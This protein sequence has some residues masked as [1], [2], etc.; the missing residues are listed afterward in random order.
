M[1]AQLVHAAK[2]YKYKIEKS[3]NDTKWEN[4]WTPGN[5]VLFTMSSLTLIGAA[6]VQS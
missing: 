6:L 2:H 3:T 5:S 1:V 4:K